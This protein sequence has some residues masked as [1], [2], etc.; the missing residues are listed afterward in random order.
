MRRIEIVNLLK[1][2][3]DLERAL[4]SAISAT[5]EDRVVDLLE[6]FLDQHPSSP[7]DDYINYKMF[8]GFLDRRGIDEATLTPRYVAR[9]GSSKILISLASK[10]PID[11]KTLEAV[12]P[13]LRQIFSILLEGSLL[14]FS[15]SVKMCMHTGTLPLKATDIPPMLESLNILRNLGMLDREML[16]KIRV[17]GLS[18]W[19]PVIIILQRRGLGHLLRGSCDIPYLDAIKPLERLAVLNE[20]YA[21]AILRR[22]V[23]LGGRDWV[24][25]AGRVI[26]L[27]RH[28][29]D[30]NDITIRKPDGTELR[31]TEVVLNILVNDLP[32][33]EDIVTA[34]D[35]LKRYNLLSAE[36]FQTLLT[37]PYL[38]NTARAL[39]RMNGLNLLTPPYLKTILSQ[40]QYMKALNQTWDNFVKDGEIREANFIFKGSISRPAQ[41]L[42]RRIMADL[43]SALEGGVSMQADYARSATLFS[44]PAAA[45]AAS[46]AAGAASASALP[47]M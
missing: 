18:P 39:S 47:M 21:N 10:T 6:Q 9:L 37:S 30:I 1:A 35:I 14:T 36:N 32:G 29:N 42:I 3:K 25:P 8:L 4:H 16:D 12:L 11:W 28:H 46:A 40:Q 5:E 41:E 15:K 45:G 33:H 43:P 17:R 31:V 44:A 24:R 19:A 34:I 23:K 38:E 20:S 7:F 27:A 13:Q 2:Y 22:P 26:G